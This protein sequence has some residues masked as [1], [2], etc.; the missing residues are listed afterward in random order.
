[1]QKQLLDVGGEQRAETLELRSSILESKNKAFLCLGNKVSLFLL[2][3]V[4]PGQVALA[5]AQLWRVNSISTAGAIFID[6]A[7]SREQWIAETIW[8][9]P[10]SES[11]KA[12]ME[13][14]ILAGEDGDYSSCC[15]PRQVLK[16]SS[17]AY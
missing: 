5:G 4:M 1:M 7:S 6:A 15:W 8:A 14:Q 17:G 16:V 13:A 12:S 11:F 3:Q 2:A 10:M 9:A